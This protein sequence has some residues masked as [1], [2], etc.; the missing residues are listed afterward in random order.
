M[1]AA[2]LTPDLTLRRYDKEAKQCYQADLRATK[3][4]KGRTWNR[5]FGYPGPSYSLA[6][7]PQT[8][9]QIFE[10][11]HQRVTRKICCSDPL[12]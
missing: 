11:T 6:L 10:T 2:G 7:S 4:T 8:V 1:V 3:F 5:S 9:E 12:F